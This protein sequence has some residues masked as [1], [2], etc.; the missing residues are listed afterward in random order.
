MR[1][2]RLSPPLICISSVEDEIRTRGTRNYRARVGDNN[3]SNRFT[4]RDFAVMKL[5]MVAETERFQS[6]VE[7]FIETIVI[8]LRRYI[9]VIFRFLRNKR[10]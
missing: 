9:N 1:P 4:S 8:C 2:K 5:L 10:D 6:W 3:D 7:V